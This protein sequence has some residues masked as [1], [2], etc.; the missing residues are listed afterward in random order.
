MN[1]DLL[2]STITPCFRMK[3]YLKKFLEELPKQTIFSQTEIVLDHNEPDEEE[4]S[5]VKEFQEKYPGRIKHLI[6]PK[7]DPIGISMN[8][9]IK[10]AGAEFVTIWN[11]DDLRTP[12][13][14]E[15]Q[16]NL[17]REN[18]EIGIAY[19]DYRVVRSF[20]STEGSLVHDEPKGEELTRSMI[21][22]PFFMFRK[23]LVEKAGYFDE[24]LRSGADF[25]MAV[26]LAFH[27]KAGMTKG[28]LGY[29]LNEGKGASTRPGSLQPLERTLIELRYGIFDKIDYDQVDRLMPYSIPYIVQDG[30]LIHVD[31][32][33]PNYKELISTRRDKWSRKGKIKYILK[34][35]T[36]YTKIRQFLASKIKKILYKVK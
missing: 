32:F 34:K 9:C 6:I 25:D 13:S 4:I 31:Q 3:P 27:T 21:I 2:V 23:N 20:G 17:L 5:W 15:Q 12:D 7:V 22:G 8:R 18:S 28:L 29:Y 26:R 35:A 1:N 14:L 19:G 11:V 30:Q 10:E 33:V 24:A 16:V 36:Y